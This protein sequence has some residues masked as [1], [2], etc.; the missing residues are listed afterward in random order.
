MTSVKYKNKTVPIKIGN[1]AMVLYEETGMSLRDFDTSP[2][3]AAITMVKCALGLKQSAADVAD[4]LPPLK[5]LV[6]T[7]VEALKESGWI[8]D[9]GDSPN[10][11]GPL[12]KNKDG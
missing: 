2:A 12:T 10:A 8:D 3:K 11:T 6:G 9:G 1:R 4:D 7:V 5:E